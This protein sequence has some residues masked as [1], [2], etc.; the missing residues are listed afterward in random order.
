MT[1]LAAGKSDI[2]SLKGHGLVGLLTIFGLFGGLV[3]WAYTMEIAGAVIAAG[4]V[5]VESHAKEIQHRDGGIVKEFFVR[6]EDVVIEGQ[7]LAVLDDTDIS[8]NLAIV[9]TQLQQALVRETRLIAEI[10]DDAEVNLSE[11]LGELSSSTQVSLLMTTERQVFAARK[12]TLS[13]RVAQLSEQ[14]TQIEQQVEG[15]LIQQGA[16]EK[17]LDILAQELLALNTLYAEQLVELGRITN[18]EKDVALKE[19]ERGQV[20]ASIAQARAA[21]AERRLQITQI[22]DDFLT[23]TLDDLQET[24]RLISEGRQQERSA[25]DRL[26]RTSLRAPDAGVVHDSIIHTIGGVVAPGETLMLLVP[27]DDNLLVNV[28]ISPIDIDKLFSSQEVTLRLSSFDQRT[29]PEIKGSITRIAP[30]RTQDPITGEQYYSANVAISEQ[31]L[32]KLP[33]SVKLLPGM[34]V[35]AFVKTEDRTVLSYLINPFAEQLNR[36]FREE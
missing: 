11:E 27:Q 9:Q 15:L 31:E 35:D 19:G 5:V 33:E 4:T 21:I 7:L 24:R 30:D 32:N 12:R 34:P 3:Y 18:F 22:H 23:T 6:D 28:R 2:S 1:D 36:A 13:G 16:I 14:I 29:T 25:L 10:A 20:I 17:Q 26:N 8:A